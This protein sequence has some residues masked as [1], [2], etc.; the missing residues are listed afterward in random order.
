MKDIFN[1][2]EDILIYLQGRHTG[3]ENAARSARIKYLFGIK[4]TQVRQAVNRL[5]CNGQPV[6]SGANGYYYA[7]NRDE[8]NSTITRLLGRARKI[9]AAAR[10]LALSRQLFC[11]G[12]E[13]TEGGL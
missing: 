2:S 4:G 8:I 1:V 6:C 5:R 10:G 9:S 11:D 3:A 7:K 12:T 13:G